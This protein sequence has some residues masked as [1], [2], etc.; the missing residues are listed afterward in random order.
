MSLLTGSTVELVTGH[1]G[2]EAPLNSGGGFTVTNLGGF[3]VTDLGGFAVTDFVSCFPWS[4]S[5]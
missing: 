5:R 2:A 1:P 4:A 3:T